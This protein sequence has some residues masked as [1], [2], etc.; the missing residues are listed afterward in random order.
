MEK[1]VLYNVD[2]LDGMRQIPDQCIDMVLCDL[3]Q[4]FGQDDW[5]IYVPFED[6]WKEYDRIVKDDGVIVLFGNGLFTADLM[7]SNR[8]LWR[9][10]LVWEKT[11]PTGLANAGYMM[12]LR[13]HEDICVFA[14][15]MPRYNP[16][17]MC[18]ADKAA[19]EAEHKRCNGGKKDFF[20]RS[21]IT[22]PTDKKVS[23]ILPA[24]KPIDLCAY[25]VKTFTD[26]GGLV[27]DCCAGSG[28]VPIACQLTGRDYIAFEDNKKYFKLAMK[29]L[30]AV[31][32]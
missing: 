14:K 9:Y 17:L 19:P 7:H 16:Q 21:V 29:R 26:E 22:F 12:P 13:A 20:P 31:K 3:S 11:K 6:L 2:C 18:G 1:N 5:D 23:S 30:G 15:Q 32:Q 24:Q 10:N 27:L 25:L 8:A 4:G 28:S